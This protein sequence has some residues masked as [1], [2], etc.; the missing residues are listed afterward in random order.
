MSDF[1]SDAPSLSPSMTGPLQDSLVE[2]QEKLREGPLSFSFA[3]QRWQNG[4]LLALQAAAMLAVGGFLLSQM[5]VTPKLQVQMAILGGL[6][7]IGGLAMLPRI[8]VDFFGSITVDHHGIHMTP[9][10]VGFSAPWSMIEKWEIK[11]CNGTT[12]AHCIRV[13]ANGSK[14]SHMVPAGFLN[15]QDLHRLRKVMVSGRPA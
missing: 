11:E 2:P 12:A 9:T 6:L 5:S 3:R 15:L 14:D 7:T 13:W 10:I 1:S 4:I 8:F